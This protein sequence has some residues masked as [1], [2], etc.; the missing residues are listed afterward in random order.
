MTKPDSSAKKCLTFRIGDQEYGLDILRV[1][2]IRSY[3]PPTRIA[4]APGWHRGVINLRG[5]IVPIV[6]LRIRLGCEAIYNTF[7]VVVVLNV[8]GRTIG[9]VVDSASDVLEVSPGQAR[10]VRSIPNPDHQ[11][12]VTYMVIVSDRQILIVDIESLLCDPAMGLIGSV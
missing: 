8:K 10:A 5:V 7:T 6:D 3:E 2:E 12:Y 1:Q 9:I 4:D 11:T